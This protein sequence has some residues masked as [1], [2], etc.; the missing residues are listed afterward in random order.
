MPQF[1]FLD[2]R[3]GKIKSAGE[4]KDFDEANEQ[5][6]QTEEVVWLWEGR[7]TIG[8]KVKPSKEGKRDA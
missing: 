4:F 8:K 3:D 6:M 1:F 2:G 5:L 7:P